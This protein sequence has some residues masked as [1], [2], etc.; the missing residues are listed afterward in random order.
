MYD[1]ALAVNAYLAAETEYVPW[2]AALTSLSYLE[3]MFT[4]T[5]G[6]GSLRVSP[7]LGTADVTAP[8]G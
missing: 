4:R 7:N 3:E 1:K 5:S 6:Y 2:D 8:S